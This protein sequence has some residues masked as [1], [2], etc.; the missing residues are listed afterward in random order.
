MMPSSRRPTLAPLGSLVPL[1]SL[2]L[3]GALLCPAPGAAQDMEP[4]P[5]EAR[6]VLEVVDALFDAMR[7]RDGEAVA[8]VFHPDAGLMSTRVADDGSPE[9]TI[10]SVAGFAEAVGAGGEPW[11]EPWFA[12]RLEVDGALAQ[13]WIFY[14][15]YVGDTFSHCGHNSIQLV[16]DAEAGWQIAHLVD[17]RRTRECDP[18]DAD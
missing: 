4:V 1:W 7:A 18:P 16:R 6:D 2:A 14:R 8:R 5:P 13:V 10:S 12:P 11:D 9:V 3:L 15:F 17:S